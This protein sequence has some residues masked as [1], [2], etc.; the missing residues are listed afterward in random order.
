M[1]SLVSAVVPA[2]AVTTRSAMRSSVV[3]CGSVGVTAWI[4]DPSALTDSTWAW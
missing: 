1:V 4:C 3:P 2:P